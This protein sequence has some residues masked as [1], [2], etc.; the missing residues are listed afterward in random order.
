[1][2]QV[3]RNV[4]VQTHR[5]IRKVS[6]IVE[7]PTRFA[8]Q[9]K[10]IS[11]EYLQA[12]S[13]LALEIEGAHSTLYVGDENAPDGAKWPLGYLN[14]FAGTIAGGTSEIQKNIFAERILGLPKTK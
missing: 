4:G 13:S 11:T 12:L 6:G 7:N 14:S 2:Q 5:R 3:I 1:M 9:D 10:F 8:L